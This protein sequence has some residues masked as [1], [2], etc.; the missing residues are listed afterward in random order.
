MRQ[1][2]SLLRTILSRPA[3]DCNL[4]LFAM[5]T[6]ALQADAFY[7]DVVEHGAVFTLLEDEGFPVLRIDGSEVIPFWSSRVRAERVRKEHPKYERYEVDEITLSDFLA[8]TL[9]LLEAENIRVG[10]NWS[11]PRLTG[12]DL[13]AIEVRSNINHRAQQKG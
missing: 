12:Y 11:G 13:S 5:S 10:V 3:L 2:L 6:A 4:S 7:T 9:Q 8:K 1:C